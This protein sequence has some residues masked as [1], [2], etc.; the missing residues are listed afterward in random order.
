MIKVKAYRKRQYY[1]SKFG[2]KCFIDG[3]DSDATYLQ[4]AMLTGKGLN[5]EEEL[6]YTSAGKTE[7]EAIKAMDN[8]LKAEQLT[9]T[10]SRIQVIK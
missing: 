6:V 5:T 3:S 10:V 4:A 8:Y 1:L 9:D 2:E 7:K